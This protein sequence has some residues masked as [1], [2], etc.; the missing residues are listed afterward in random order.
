MTLLELDVEIS[1]T[2]EFSAE[3]KTVRV[4][5]NTTFKITLKGQDGNAIDVS[6]ATTITFKFLKPK[7]K[8]GDTVSKSGTL[9]NDGTDGIVQ[10]IAADD[11]LDTEGIWEVQVYILLSDGTDFHSNINKFRVTRKI[12]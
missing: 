7:Q 9:T 2:L 11:L 10:H 1:Q 6:T 3:M 5:D 12:V 4:G 8:S